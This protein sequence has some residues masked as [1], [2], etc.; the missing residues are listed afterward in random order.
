M[1]NIEDDDIPPIVT[2]T[3]PW[4]D[5]PRL[6]FGD[7]E[8]RRLNARPGQV[9]FNPREMTPYVE[10]YREAAQAL[11]KHIDQSPVVP[12]N[13]MLFPLAHLW[14]HHVELSL[15]QIIAIGRCVD[16]GAWGFPDNQHGLTKLWEEAK[17]YVIQCGPPG[18]TG[19]TGVVANVEANIHEFETIES[20]RPGVPLLARPEA[21]AE[22]SRRAPQR[23]PPGAAR[24]DDGAR[25]LPLRGHHGAR[26]RLGEPDARVG[27][28]PFRIDTPACEH[29]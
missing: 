14:R 28:G 4:P 15:K 17:P 5:V 7:G 20:D 21:E 29:A 19:A 8:D 24:D 22:P 6:V 26:A 25:E 27:T 9:L 13:F 1:A 12:V 10:G 16:G 23:E 11:F 2:G 3:V 18:D